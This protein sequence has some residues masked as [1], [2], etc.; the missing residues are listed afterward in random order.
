MNIIKKFMGAGVKEDLMSIPSGQ[1]DLLRSSASPKASLECIYN[2]AILIIR[3]TGQFQYELV[4]RRNSDAEESPS[5]DSSDDYSDDTASI[6]S[7]QSKITSDEWVFPLS[8][9]LKFYKN[10]NDNG[11]ITFVWK[12]TIGDEDDEKVQFVLSPE[13]PMT[14]ADQFLLLIHRCQYETKFKKSSVKAS[15]DDLAQ[16]ETNELGI[17]VENTDLVGELDALNITSV[18]ETEEFQDAKDT[19]DSNQHN[20]GSCNSR[21]NPLVTLEDSRTPSPLTKV[22]E[23]EEQC[24]LLASI[25]LYDPIQET[26]ILQDDRVKVCIVETGR[27]E[28]WL[29]IEGEKVKLG[30]DISPSI[31]PTFE[32]L[33]S[34][35]IF[36]Y[37]FNSV[38]LSYTIKFSTLKKCIE[39]QSIWSKCLWMTLHK[40]EWE[41]V[42]EN[43][44]EYILHATTAPIE[45]RLDEI[46]A[47]DNGNERNEIEDDEEEEES[48]N[49]DDDSEYSKTIIG[50]ESFDEGRAKSTASLDTNKSLTIAFKN[51]RSYVVRGNKIGVFK[52]DE[53]D[54]LEFVTA[55]KSVSTL[56]GKTLDPRNPMLYMGDRSMILSDS[57]TKNKLYK[58]DLERGQIVEEWSTGDKNLVQYGPTKKFDQLTAEQT[59]LG[60]SQKG[61]FKIDPRINTSNKVVQEQSK[62]YVTKY[63]FSSLGTT[64][65]GYIAVGSERGDIKLYD[66]LGIRAKTAI[67]S[68]G[69]PIKHLI[70]SA[71]GKWLLAT[72][73]RS[74]LLLDLTVKTGK[75][76]GNVGF[77]KPFPSSEVVKTYILKI[78]PEHTSYI[79][80]FTKK[81]VS[82]SKAYFNTGVGKQEEMILTS[83]GP[84]AVSWSLKKVI[85]GD[86]NPYVIRRYENDIVEDN[87]EFGTNKKVIVALKDDVSLSKIKSFK[88]PNKDVLMP[89]S[90]LKD[91]YK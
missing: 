78:S 73:D 23:G 84:F 12:N 22:P 51:N 85:R 11:K 26:F 88:K 39:F 65:S 52:T 24:R 34:S 41:K 9:S 46:L 35:F 1:F 75:N 21:D 6:L 67:P 18:D 28:F 29:A 14:E 90:S 57:S 17:T 89:K 63:K 37:Y 76:S 77:L 8:E 68:L 56:D 10:W 62:D 2:D 19:V 33:N 27:Y 87:F 80:T 4:V 58:M 55:I 47:V 36:N 74:L 32:L 91:F 53:D 49:E 60:I 15:A 81:P 40:Q 20:D 3:E 16:F 50:S 42:S 45:E 64:E 30:T 70:V 44:K 13:M 25:Y 86:K 43:E 72:C 66:R 71:D 61:L 48:E 7:S 83:T 54:D 59:L 5:G 82:F 38:V 69:E 31:N 79:S